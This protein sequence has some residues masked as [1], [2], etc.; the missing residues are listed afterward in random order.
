MTWSCH[1]KISRGPNREQCCSRHR[2][3]H[4]LGTYLVLYRIWW[5]V[6]PLDHLQSSQSS[7]WWKAPKLSKYREWMDECILPRVWDAP[8]NGQC[9][10]NIAIT[11]EHVSTAWT[12]LYTMLQ[13]IEMYV[14]VDEWG[15][16]Q[17]KTQ[18]FFTIAHLFDSNDESKKR[19]M[20]PRINHS[21]L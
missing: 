14:P 11:W 8:T 1:C 17:R 5:P 6:T 20:N 19:V 21:S 7:Q 15:Q 10:T 16:C 18:Q 12:Q 2:C 3:M 9:L 13:C 4:T